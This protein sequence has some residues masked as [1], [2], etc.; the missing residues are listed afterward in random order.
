MESVN[1]GRIE[2]KGVA[3]AA[4]EEV[5]AVVAAITN[6][7]MVRVVT[8]VDLEED[9]V[10]ADS[11]EAVVEKDVVLVMVVAMEVSEAAEEDLEVVEAVMIVVDSEEVE[12][13][14]ILIDD[15]VLVGS[16]NQ[17][18]LPPKTKKSLLMINNLTKATQRNR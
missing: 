13:V 12:V 14:A 16:V 18:E 1:L 5:V 7:E 15:K 2:K 4:V 10:E 11:E 9:V 3:L 6:L 17:K 8:K